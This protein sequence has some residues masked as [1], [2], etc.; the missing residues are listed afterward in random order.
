MP[1]GRKTE[2]RIN[3]SRYPVTRSNTQQLTVDE[4]CGRIMECLQ[5]AEAPLES[6]TIARSFGDGCNCWAVRDGLQRL[7]DIGVVRKIGADGWILTQTADSSNAFPTIDNGSTVVSSHVEPSSLTTTK[8]TTLA[9]IAAQMTSSSRGQAMCSSTS[10]ITSSSNAFPAINIGSTVGS[11]HVEQSSLATTAR[12]TVAATS[13][14]MTPSSRGQAMDSSTSQITYSS[15]AFSTINKGSTVGSFLVEQSSLPTTTC[16]TVAAITDQM[17]SSSRGQAMVSSTSQITKNSSD[18]V[19]YDCDGNAVQKNIKKLKR[20]IEVLKTSEAPVSG[21]DIAVKADL[22]KTKGDVNRHL[23]L[24]EQKGVLIR[25]GNLWK[26]ERNIDGSDYFVYAAELSKNETST[27]QEAKLD[28]STTCEYGCENST[29]NCYH[30]KQ[31]NH[32]NMYNIQVG[33]GNRLEIHS[34]DDRQHRRTEYSQ[35]DKQL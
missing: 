3:L 24:L 1:K 16:T 27:E 7:K 34:R 28:Q 4:V 9:A 23:Y 29:G 18:L 6:P 19:S 17:T 21:I 8:C 15:N 35:T 13:D 30:I 20:I 10:Q 5:K 31:E 26:L 25:T 33:D 32:Y 11:S 14:Q 12:I 22:G 2:K